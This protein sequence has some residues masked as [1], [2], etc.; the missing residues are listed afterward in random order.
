MNDPGLEDP[1]QDGAKTVDQDKEE[2]PDV[3][4]EEEQAFLNPR[5]VC[6]TSPTRASTN[7]WSRVVA[8]G[9]RPRPFH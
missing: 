2:E 1:I 5:S 3:Q 7:L 8:G 6:P 9:L 4:E